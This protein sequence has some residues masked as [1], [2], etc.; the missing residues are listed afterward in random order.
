MANRVFVGKIHQSTS[1]QTLNDEFSK[2]GEVT[3]IDLKNGYAFIFYATEEDCTEAINTLNGKEIDGNAIVVEATRARTYE[4]S[5][6]IKRFDLRL[7]VSGLGNRV[8]WQDLKDW[9]RKAG[10]VTFTNIFVKD[11]VTNGVIEFAVR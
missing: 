3:K 11:G 6:P 8:S 5:R 2:C 9:A 1:E 7:S 4:K 10:D